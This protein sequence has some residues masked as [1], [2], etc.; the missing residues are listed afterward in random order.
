MI[1]TDEFNNA[2]SKVRAVQDAYLNGSITVEEAKEMTILRETGFYPE[3]V[4]GVYQIATNAQLMM[5]GE[6]A[7]TGEVGK[8][9]ADISNV[10]YSQMLDNLYGILDGNGHKITLNMENPG[11]STAL[12][13]SMKA[14]AEVRNLTIDGTINTEGQYAASIATL[15]PPTTATFLPIAIGVRWLGKS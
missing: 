4:D 6:L 13:N 12:I 10:T 5:F 1:T 2:I 9:V 7:T 3:M 8:L 14:K 15:P 11:S